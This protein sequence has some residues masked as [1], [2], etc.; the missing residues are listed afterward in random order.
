MESIRVLASFLAAALAAGPAHALDDLTG[1]WEGTLVCNGANAAL[2][3]H[4]KSQIAITIDDDPSGTAYAQIGGI[5]RLGVIPHPDSP[6]KG[7]VAGFDCAVSPDFA[8][9]ALDVSVKVKPGSELGTMRGQLVIIGA[10]PTPSVN[11]CKIKAKRVETTIP[12]PI[13]GCPP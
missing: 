12:A 11:T 8:G 5:Y 9:Y 1:K 2:W 3:L 4:S 7:R 6:S 13:P 10:V